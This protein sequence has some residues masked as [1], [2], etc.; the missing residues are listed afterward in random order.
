MAG[1]GLFTAPL[2]TLFFM[3]ARPP[4]YKKCFT[5]QRCSTKTTPSNTGRPL[6]VMLFSLPTAPLGRRSRPTIISHVNTNEMN[7]ALGHL[8]AHID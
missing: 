7:R 3:G 8:C 5:S 6:T 1:P 4:E 2:C